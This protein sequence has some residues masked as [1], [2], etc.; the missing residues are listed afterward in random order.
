MKLSSQEKMGADWSDYKAPQYRVKEGKQ[1]PAYMERSMRL[2][3][4]YDNKPGSGFDTNEDEFV[5][6]SIRVVTW[7]LV[8]LGAAA[9]TLLLMTDIVKN[10]AFGI[11][12][13]VVC[14][15]LVRVVV[16]MTMAP[17]TLIDWLATRMF[18]APTR[19][20]LYVK[21]GI[22]RDLIEIDTR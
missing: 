16:W 6:H 19:P 1:V 15:M 2:L 5:E 18:N 7:L 3:N 22:A 14:S 21:Q 11:V 4:R 17:E 8:A 12:A 20:R 10:L 13:I 9:T